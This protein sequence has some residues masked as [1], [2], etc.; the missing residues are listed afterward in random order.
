MD[1]IRHAGGGDAWRQHPAADRRDTGGGRD[2]DREIRSGQHRETANTRA[3]LAFAIR[4]MPEDH[5]TAS[6]P[7][8]TS[9]MRADPHAHVTQRR[10]DIA[11]RDRTGWLGS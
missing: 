10:S 4:T 5:E 1:G 7:L 9:R 11:H 3:N 2:G 8:A 6:P